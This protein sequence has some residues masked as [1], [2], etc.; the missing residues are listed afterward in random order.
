[1]TTS[2]LTIHFDLPKETTSLILRDH[3]PP[4]FSLKRAH[5]VL[6]RLGSVPPIPVNILL[7]PPSLQASFTQSGNTAYIRVLSYFLILFPSLDVIAA[8]PLVNH[9]IVNNIYILITGHDTS[10]K[11][12]YRCDRLL[13]IFLHIITGILPILAGFGVANLIYIL[14]YGGLAGFVCYFFPSF[15]QFFSIQVCKKKFSTAFT[16]RSN[17]HSAL[18][19]SLS[20]ELQKSPLL[21]KDSKTNH[22]QSLYMTPYSIR[23]LSHPVCVWIVWALGMMLCVLA[24]VGLFVHPQKQTC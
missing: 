19:T 15:L 9:V 12:K 10:R 17:S 8:Y 13:R 16:S 24:F 23:F 18:E 20:N 5:R 21:P 11:P 6:S 22:G 14:K 7:L 2:H 4:H 1:M 3:L